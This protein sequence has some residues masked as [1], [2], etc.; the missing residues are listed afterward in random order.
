ME[1]TEAEHKAMMDVNYWGAFHWIRLILPQMKKRGCGHIVNISSG[2][3]KIGFSVTSGYSAS[4]FALTGFSEAL[5][6]EL[7]GT[8]LR[9][10]CVHPGQYKYRFLERRDN[11][12][13]ES[14]TAYPICTQ[15]VSGVY[16][17]EA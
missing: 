17:P 6:R 14:A 2:A 10:S 11:P 15:D 5:H 12:A 9:I 4:K 13:N 16:R 7:L 1:V 8:K 3:G